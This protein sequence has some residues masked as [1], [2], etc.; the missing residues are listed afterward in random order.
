M[1]FLQIMILALVQGAAELLPVSS[2]AHV[3]VAEKLMGLNPVSPEM[4]LLLVMLHTGTMFAVLI[5]FWKSW[6][7]CF[8]QSGR[9]SR[10]FVVYIVAA[11]G[12]TGAVG[13][14]LKF[15][16]EKVFLGNIPHAE[17]ELIFGNMNLIAVS[18]LTVG[19]LII[20]AGLKRQRKSDFGNLDLSNSCL[21]G[22]VQGICLPFRGFSRSGATISAGL[23]MGVNKERLEA[24]SFALAVVLTPPVIVREVLR[25][26]KANESQAVTVVAPTGMVHLFLPGL[27]GMVLSFFAG[28]LALKWLSNWLEKGR[29]Q[30]FGYYCV[31]AS[32][33]VIALNTV[34]VF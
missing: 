13:L 8:L 11:T 21:I 25:L 30:V 1:S 2:S 27:L 4:T 10:E 34:G 6:K 24:F 15:I 14:T 19:I 23:V 33:V 7:K 16:I 17:I 29:W 22:A 31:C 20:Y 3:I 5:Y 28:L 9:A 12:F 18:L 26:L 32:I